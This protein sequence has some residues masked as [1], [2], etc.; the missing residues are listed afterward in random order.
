[1]EE[2]E[3]REMLR[4]GALELGVGLDEGAVSAFMTL[5]RELKA[6]NRKINLTSIEGDAEIVVRHFL[7]S[8]TLC[9]F[10]DGTE[11]L[12]DVGTGAGFPGI[13][14]KIAMPGLASVLLDSVAKKVHF[15]RHIIRTLGLGGTVKGSIEAVSGRVEDRALVERYAGTFDCVVSRAFSELKDFVAVGRPYLKPGGRLIAM[16]GPAYAGELE[17]AGLEGLS[18]PEVHKVRLP[19]TDIVTVHVVFTRQNP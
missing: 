14:L 17:V 11:R 10:L 18:A 15:I 7:D 9:R 13:P 1:M 8:L 6:W 19:S 4:E 3:L 2:K 5:L 12:L 16:K